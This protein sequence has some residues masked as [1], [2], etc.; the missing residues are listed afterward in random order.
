MRL[1]PELGPSGDKP[2]SWVSSKGV[3]IRRKPLTSFPGKPDAYGRLTVSFS[4]SFFTF[5]RGPT[6]D[7]LTVKEA[8]PENM[9]S[10]GFILS[11]YE[12]S[13]WMIQLLVPCTSRPQIRRR[14][15]YGRSWLRLDVLPKTASLIHAIIETRS[16]HLHIDVWGTKY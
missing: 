1:D 10:R 13:R 9:V 16:H 3:S 15:R 6:I 8:S 4:L 2:H 7:I 11:P 12:L 14:A 5:D